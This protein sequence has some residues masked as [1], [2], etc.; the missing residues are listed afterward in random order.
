MSNQKI[1]IKLN[2]YVS[3]DTLHKIP[4]RYIVL[5]GGR[6]NG[7]RTPPAAPAPA[8]MKDDPRDT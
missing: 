2:K 1:K 8:R 4:A 5:V 3:R 7:T 6:D